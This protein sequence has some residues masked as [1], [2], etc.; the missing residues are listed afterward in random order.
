MMSEVKVVYETASPRYV[1]EHFYSS[2]QWQADGGMW[3]ADRGFESLESAKE[4]ADE[5][6][7]IFPD[8]K[9][10]VADNEAW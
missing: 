7:L 10:R 1:V 6:Q 9:F 2:N 4:Y 5:Q 8:S 3:E